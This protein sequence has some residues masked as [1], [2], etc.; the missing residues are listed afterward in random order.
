[1]RAAYLHP[2]TEDNRTSCRG[3]VGSNYDGG[4]DYELE[5]GG[6]CDCSFKMMA[7]AVHYD[8]IMEVLKR[9]L[10]GPLGYMVLRSIRQEEE[11]LIREFA[12]REKKSV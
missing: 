11:R 1:M 8:E 7:L 4:E 10:A 3:G 12:A 2:R 6:N 9:D 5:I